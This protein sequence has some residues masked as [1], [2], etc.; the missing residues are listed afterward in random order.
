[1]AVLTSSDERR[2]LIESDGPGCASYVRKPAD[3]IEFTKAVG[4]LGLYWLI[5]NEPLPEEGRT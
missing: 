4:Q 2:D 1:M 3:F 5:L